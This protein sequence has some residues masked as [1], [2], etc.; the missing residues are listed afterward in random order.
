MIATWSDTLAAEVIANL[1]VSRNGLRGACG[2]VGPQRMRSAFPFQHAA[3]PLQMLQQRAALHGDSLSIIFCII[4]NNARKL[5]Y[6]AHL[7]LT[8][9]PI[10]FTMTGVGNC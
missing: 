9:A 6:A 2:R 7:I 3:V 1:V 10:S 8:I 5:V 4:D